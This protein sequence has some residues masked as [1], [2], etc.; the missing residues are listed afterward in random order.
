M[1]SLGIQHN[2]VLLVEDNEDDVFLMRRLFKKEAI[3]SKLNVVTDG[4]EAVKYLGGEEKYVD[5]A[6]FPIP[7]VVF[8]DLKLPFLHGFD[9]LS[10][11]R[12]QADLAALPVIVLSSSLE[13]KDKEKAKAFGSP[14]LVKP[15]SP[16]ALKE[17]I[18]LAATKAQS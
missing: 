4:K 1:S 15:P 17:A 11:I 16:I 9:V 7:D 8:L 3:A 2:T 6:E 14:Y 13:D 10:W 5:R 12:T 18:S